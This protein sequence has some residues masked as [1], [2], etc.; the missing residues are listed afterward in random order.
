MASEVAQLRELMELRLRENG[1]ASLVDVLAEFDF[2]N[3]A[4]P[5]LWKWRQALEQITPVP[6]LSADSLHLELSSTRAETANLTDQGLARIVELYRASI[7]APVFR[8]GA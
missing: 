5:S 2:R 1:R 6:T 3:H 4:L 7:M 8:T